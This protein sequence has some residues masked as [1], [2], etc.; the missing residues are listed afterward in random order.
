MVSPLQRTKSEELLSADPDSS[1]VEE[2]NP[3]P[4]GMGKNQVDK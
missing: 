1:P 4:K 3:A 2:Q